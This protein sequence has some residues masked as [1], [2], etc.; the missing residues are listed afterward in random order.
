[1]SSWWSH[2]PSLPTSQSLQIGPRLF[3]NHV[4]EMKDF[5]LIKYIIAGTENVWQTRT[6][7]EYFR[8]QS[9]IGKNSSLLSTAKYVISDATNAWHRHTAARRQDEYVNRYYEK[10]LLRGKAG[11]ADQSTDSMWNNVGGAVLRVVTQARKKNLL[12]NVQVP[13]MLRWN[14]GGQKYDTPQPHQ[15]LSPFRDRESALFPSVYETCRGHG[16]L[17]GDNILIDEV[18]DG[19]WLIDF[20]HTGW[21]PILQDAVELESSVHFSLLDEND[22][23]RLLELEAALGSQPAFALA[24]LPPID[25]SGDRDKELRKAYAV[26][27]AIREAAKGISGAREE[28]YLLALI[29]H[30]LRVIIDDR[31]QRDADMRPPWFF[32]VHALCLASF[33]CHQLS[34]SAL[35]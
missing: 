10:R 19:K 20:E 15:Y 29:Y 9:D 18:T 3:D 27:R 21:G 34:K 11:P 26:I 6:F 14:I 4:Y 1:M 7:S 13:T 31:P 32:Q 22:L 30:S 23:D 8:L 12:D 28:D 25:M 33:C 5:G 17:H 2:E 35:A 16:D 24:E